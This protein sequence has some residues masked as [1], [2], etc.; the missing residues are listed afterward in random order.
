MN[1]NTQP[2][3]KEI[4]YCFSVSVVRAE[5]GGEYS[6]YIDAAKLDRQTAVR[7]AEQ[8]QNYICTDCRPCRVYVLG[9]DGIPVYAAGRPAWMRDSLYWAAIGHPECPVS[10]TAPV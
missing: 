4:I 7:R 5:G 8:L 6:S 3:G 9:A 1:T 2:D 10:A